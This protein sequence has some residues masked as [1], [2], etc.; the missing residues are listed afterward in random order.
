MTLPGFRHVTDYGGGRSPEHER[1]DRHRML[2]RECLQLLLGVA[3]HLFLKL[4]L[5]EWPLI[6]PG[7]GEEGKHMQEEHMRLV[8]CG[9]REGFQQGVLRVRRKIG[10]YQNGMHLHQDG[11]PVW[12]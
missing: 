10:G 1:L 5:W 4:R 8:S 3:L 11:F 2:S 9:Y 7:H 6:G 12:G